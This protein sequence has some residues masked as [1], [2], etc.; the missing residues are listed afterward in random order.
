METAVETAVENA[1]ETAVEN[2]VE[3][4]VETSNETLSKTRELCQAILDRPDFGEMR[5]KLD[6][7]MADEMAKFQYQM[8]NDRG[9]VL[10][11]KQMNGTPITDEEIGQFEALREGFLKNP[12]A[13]DFLSAQDE[14]QKLQEMVMKHIHKTFELGRV[15]AAEDFEQSCCSTS[16]GCGCH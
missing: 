12:V 10:Q 15:P 8:L 1:V 3:T 7:F 14:L 6:A 5:R 13:S 2:A 16:G 9:G 4:A 11:Q